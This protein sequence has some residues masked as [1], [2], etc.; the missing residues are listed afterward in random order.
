MDVE[1]RTLLGLAM[2]AVVGASGAK[3]QTVGDSG[4]VAPPDPTEI[5]RLWP[6]GA[7]GGQGVTVTP[8]VP[9]R[10]TDPAFHDRYAQ[11][12]TDP[13]LT[14]FRP[15]AAERF[16]DAPHPRRRLS[17]GGAGQGGV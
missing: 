14:V 2:V 6:D 4:R 9:E 12:T 3:A 13:I 16:G 17:L 5:I 8:V 15:R 1:R 10:S 7:P 11:Y